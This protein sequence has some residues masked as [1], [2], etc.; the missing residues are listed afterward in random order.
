MSTI[1][2]QRIAAVRTLEAMGYAFRDEWM[3]PAGVTTPGTP[4][5]DVMHALASPTC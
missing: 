2:K 3:P 1:D 5:A 4:E